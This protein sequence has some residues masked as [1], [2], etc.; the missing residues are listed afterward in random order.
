MREKKRK[1]KKKRKKE[2][3]KHRK[4]TTTTLR[5]RYSSFNHP[6]HVAFFS[7]SSFDD[8]VPTFLSSIELFAFSTSNENSQKNEANEQAS[9]AAK[10][11]SI[12]ALDRAS[13]SVIRKCTMADVLNAHFVHEYV[14]ED[15]EKEGKKKKELS[16]LSIGDEEEHIF[17]IA[18][19]RF[20]AILSE[21]LCE[22]LGVSGPLSRSSSSEREE[23]RRRRVVAINLRSDNFVPGRTTHDRVTDNARR[24]FLR[25]TSSSGGKLGNIAGDGG[26]S[27]VLLAHFE[28]GNEAIEIERSSFAS[29]E[30]AVEISSRKIEKCTGEA[31]CEK[32]GKRLFELVESF[33]RSVESKESAA[34][35]SGEH[36]ETLRKI[37]EIVSV[38]A[39]RSRQKEKKEEA[40][41][42]SPSACRLHTARWSGF[43]TSKH[44]E[45][46]LKATNEMIEKDDQFEFCVVCAHAF[47]NQPS[48]EA[49]QTTTRTKKK[50]MKMKNSSDR[51]RKQPSSSVEGECEEEQE[52]EILAPRTCAF[53]VMQNQRY[54]SFLPIT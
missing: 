18:Q 8:F 30:N 35:T 12:D 41:K 2:S 31:K 51:K 28:V 16:L 13:F 3:S 7:S 42:E 38:A 23:E 20:E 54:V 52:V 25:Q 4:T 1:E 50:M 39:L 22:R 45:R 17:S 29:S 36:E 48:C 24:V 14:K 19:G 9:S 46:A 49:L 33:R 47:P 11:L 6:K 53:L 37:L 44:L 27:N 5:C 32:E 15:E 10:I 26:G 40:A 34:I 21:R 43:L